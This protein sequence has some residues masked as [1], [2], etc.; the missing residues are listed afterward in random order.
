[1]MSVWY[2]FGIHHYTLYFAKTFYVRRHAVDIALRHQF[3][4]S[5]NH[6]YIHTDR[7]MAIKCLVAVSLLS[8][9][10]L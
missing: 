10:Q 4:N 1:M 6:Q 3:V 5:F 8:N 9:Y 2:S 7:F